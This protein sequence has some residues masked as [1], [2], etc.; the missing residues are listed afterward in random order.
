M[1]RSCLLRSRSSVPSRWAMIQDGGDAGLLLGG[2]GV[3]GMS[4][5]AGGGVA[6]RGG[7][8][9]VVRRGGPGQEMMLLGQVES[10]F[11]ESRGEGG[12]VCQHVAVG[13]WVESSGV[14]PAGRGFGVGNPVQVGCLSD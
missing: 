9:V 8:G 5:G 4:E 10:G 14:Q 11:H 13:F 7:L 1:L 12:I 2:V 3:H 6:L